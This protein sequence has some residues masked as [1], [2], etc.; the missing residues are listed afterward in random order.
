MTGE[1]TRPFPASYNVDVKEFMPVAK[2][3]VS[4]VTKA[5]AN[6]E[7]ESLLGLVDPEC[8]TQ[9]RSIM[10]SLDQ[11]QRDLCVLDPEDVFFS[12]ISNVTNCDKG[13]NL[14]LVF[15]S[16]PKLGSI[17]SMVEENKEL[18][19]KMENEDKEAVKE[20]VREIIMEASEKIKTNDPYYLFKENEIIIGNYRMVRDQGTGQWTIAEVSQIC[21]TQAWQFPFRLRW[22]GRLSIATRSEIK[23]NNVLRFDYASDYIVLLIFLAIMA[24]PMPQ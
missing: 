16:L 12:F 3:A 18:R 4:I 20:S 14:N 5:M 19:R 23:F 15:F 9:L 13:N 21:S 1:P 17:K 8:I 11:E 7:W 24:T 22:K 6:Q 2:G 10:L